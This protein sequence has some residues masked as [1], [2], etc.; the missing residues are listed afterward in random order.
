MTFTFDDA[1]DTLF[2][3]MAQG[4]QHGD[5]SA[6]VSCSPTAGGGRLLRIEAGK[7]YLFQISPEELTEIL[8]NHRWIF[9]EAR[10]QAARE[11]TQEA[12]NKPDNS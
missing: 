4:M 6:S 12:N 2:E 8:A 1:I 11:A 10:V 9:H 5:F 3:A 7:R